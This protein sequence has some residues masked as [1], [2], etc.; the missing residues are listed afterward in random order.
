MYMRVGSMTEWLDWVVCV[1]VC[2]R[3]VCVRERARERERERERERVVAMTYENN[4]CHILKLANAAGLSSPK[5]SP[6]MAA[7]GNNHAKVLCLYVFSK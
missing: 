3:Y 6:R 5:F 2:M 1:R 4:T 7:Q